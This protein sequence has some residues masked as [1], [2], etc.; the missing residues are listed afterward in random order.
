MRF[1]LKTENVAALESVL[2]LRQQDIEKDIKS[3]KTDEFAAICQMAD[4][5]QLWN[6]IWMYGANSYGTREELRAAKSR[7]KESIAATQALIAKV[8]KRG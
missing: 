5:I 6:K 7:V 4:V 1:E 2:T 8:F 3:G